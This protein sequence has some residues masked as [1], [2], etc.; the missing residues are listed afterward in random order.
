MLG[1]T[2]FGLVH[3]L[4][5]LVAVIAGAISFMLDGRISPRNA[6][7]KVYVVFTIASCLTAL[8]IFHH[9][10][11]GPPHVVAVLTLGVL[12]LAACARL[13][14]VFGRGSRYVETISYSATFLFH[15]IPAVTETTTRLPLGAPLIENAD[16]PTLKALY[17]VMLIAFLVGAAVQA[18][19]LRHDYTLEMR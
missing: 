3:T 15:M 12:A 19:Q 18:M 11:F 6:L 13:T 14:G 5:S 2:L 10:G 16:S 8:G 1:L 9:G 7:G 17:L 4:I